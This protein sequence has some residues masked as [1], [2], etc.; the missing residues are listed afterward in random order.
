MRVNVFV[1]YGRS[2]DFILP[3]IHEASYLQRLIT[4]STSSVGGVRLH[5]I[6]SFISPTCPAPIL[7]PAP[8][9]NHIILMPDH[10]N[11]NQSHGV[12]TVLVRRI[13]GR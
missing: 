1:S 8:T 2:A 5:G 11:N 4:G 10:N 12:S 13:H 7:P 9:L 6:K 3:L